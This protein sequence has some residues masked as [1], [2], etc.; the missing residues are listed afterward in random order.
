MFINYILIKKSVYTIREVGTTGKH[1]VPPPS[2]SPPFQLV[3]S[4][5][6]KSIPEE[7]LTVSIPSLIPFNYCH[8]SLQEVLPPIPSLFPCWLIKK[9]YLN[10]III[11]TLNIV[12]I[13]YNSVILHRRVETGRF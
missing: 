9:D 13:F 10:Y 8:P 11:S 12:N 4:C 6:P 3:C 1:V 2:H 5:F 7:S